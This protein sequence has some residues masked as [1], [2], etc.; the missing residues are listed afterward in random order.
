M[1]QVLHAFGG[2]AHM[3]AGLLV[4]TVRAARGGLSL[5]KGFDDGRPEM[6]WLVGSEGVID[7]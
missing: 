1:L 6:R 4:D 2:G 5:N 7:D 3:T